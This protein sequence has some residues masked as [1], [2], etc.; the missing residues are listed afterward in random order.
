MFQCCL[1]NKTD[2]P[3]VIPSVAKDLFKSLQCTG[4]FGVFTIN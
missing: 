2:P 3:F 4:A 1:N